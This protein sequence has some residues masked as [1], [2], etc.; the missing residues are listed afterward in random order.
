MTSQQTHTTT[1][2]TLY[3]DDE[4][5][6]KPPPDF[7]DPVDA[8]G[9]VIDAQPTYDRLINAELLLPQDGEFQATL[10][11]LMAKLTATILRIT[12]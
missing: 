5:E 7:T 2:S 10:W 11:A 9:C 8:T 12:K 4:E 6:H 1:I 3:D